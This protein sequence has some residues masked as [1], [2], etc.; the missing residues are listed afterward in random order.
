MKTK[1]LSRQIR[2]KVVEK[3]R[4]GLGSRKI[5]YAKRM[6]PINT[7]ILS[8]EAI[9]QIQQTLKELQKSTREYLPLYHLKLYTPHSL[10]GREARKKPIA[11]G[12]KREKKR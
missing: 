3:Y 2:Y 4:S 10:N 12:N 9:N 8:K 11:K 7:H 5:Q 6:L 1:E